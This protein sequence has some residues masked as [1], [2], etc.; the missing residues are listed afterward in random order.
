M[1]VELLAGFRDVDEVVGHPR[2]LVRWRLR[3]ADV[4]A[5]VDR[6]RVHRHDLAAVLLGERQRQSGLADG[7]RSADHGNRGGGGFVTLRIGAHAAKQCVAHFLHASL[8]ATF[9]P[10]AAGPDSG[11]AGLET[12][13]IAFISDIHSNTE[14]LGVVLDGIRSLGADRVQCLGDVIGYGPEPRETLLKIIEVCELSL[15]GNHEQGCMFYA[16]DFNP[17]ARQAIDWTRDQLNRRDCPREENSVLWNFLD[18]MKETH[19]ESDYLLAH[20]SPRDPVK[21]YLVPKDA[22]DR[23]KMDGCFQLFGDARLCFVGHSHVPGVYPE[24]G[25]YRAPSDFPDGYTPADGERA[26]VNIGSVGQPRDG[27]TRASFVTYDGETVRFHRARVRPCRDRGEDPRHPRTAG[28]PGG[29]PRQGALNRL[30]IL[31]ARGEPVPPIGW[32]HVLSQVTEPDPLKMSTALSRARLFACAL[33]SSFATARIRRRPRLRPGLPRQPRMRTSSSRRC[34]GRRASV[35]I[36][37]GFNRYGACVTYVNLLD[38]RASSIHAE[39]ERRGVSARQRVVDARRGYKP[40]TGSTRRS[41]SGTGATRHGS[42]ETVDPRTALVDRHGERSATGVV[43]ALE[44][45]DGL[46]FY[47]VLLATRLRAEI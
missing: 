22:E 42:A 36:R 28:L 10:L 45:G 24:A 1:R 44:L 16:S 4:H 38:H 26:I 19:R 47:Q 7:R 25:G 27:D 35:G 30:R 11:A 13:M 8:T 33:A 37:I 23:A 18:S 31:A 3:R 2:A 5:A 41:P 43:F 14:A 40:K 32:P 29:S 39:D 21:E 9:R 20:G 17:K 12:A 34:S 6:H 15:L 46:T